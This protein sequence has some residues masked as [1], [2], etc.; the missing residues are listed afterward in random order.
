MDIMEIH[1]EI[2][3]IRFFDDNKAFVKTSD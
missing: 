2:I 3:L 1:G